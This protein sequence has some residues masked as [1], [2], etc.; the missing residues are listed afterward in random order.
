MERKRESNTISTTP[1]GHDIEPRLVLTRP[2][3]VKALGHPLRTTILQLLA[4]RAAS[5]GELSVA[6]DRPRSTVAYHVG[7]LESAGL[8]R[9]VRTER[10][11]AVDER[12]Y[13]RTARTVTV[14]LE[15]GDEARDFNDF[16]VAAAESRWAYDEGKL[17]AF[18]RHARITEEQAGEIWRR[19][20]DVVETWD[21][22]PRSGETTYGLAAGVYPVPDY[23]TLA[24]PE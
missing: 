12:Y 18:L 9:V 11:R 24:D 7:V 5:I 21:R 23:P 19:I 13:G 3:Q 22:L 4:E 16:A 20:R 10:V 8:V 17:W 6:T 2:D 15:A 1:P 14:S